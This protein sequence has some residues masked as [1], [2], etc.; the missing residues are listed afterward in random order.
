MQPLV[1][2]PQDA[3]E[4]VL[5]HEDVVLFAL[6][7]VANRNQI[8]PWSICMGIVRRPALMSWISGITSSM[9]YSVM[10][11]I[12]TKLVNKYNVRF[13]ADGFSVDGSP[14]LRCKGAAPPVILANPSAL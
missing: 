11:Q 8:H 10:R 5:P 2:A 4:F 14:L 7:H 12:I 6:V 3:A 9:H 13:E 1:A